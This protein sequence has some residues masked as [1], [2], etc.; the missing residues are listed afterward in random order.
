M[1]SSSKHKK[2]HLIA[3]IA[4][5]FLLMLLLLYTLHAAAPICCSCFSH[6]DICISS[7]EPVSVKNKHVKI[8]LKCLKTMNILTSV[9]S[10]LLLR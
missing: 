2:N 5:I 4:E 6:P 3:A 1:G 8:S 10:S 9:S 7:F